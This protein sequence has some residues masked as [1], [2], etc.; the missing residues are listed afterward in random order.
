MCLLLGACDCVLSKGM[1][2]D[3]AGHFSIEM[4]KM[5]KMVEMVAIVGVFRAWLYFTAYK[6]LDI[7]P[8][9]KYIY[10][11]IYSTLR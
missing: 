5:V 9:L 10:C 3:L 1:S 11:L 2:W 4:V 6:N 8:Y 7:L